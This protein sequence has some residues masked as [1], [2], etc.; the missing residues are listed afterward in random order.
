[1]H[2]YEPLPN[3]KPSFTYTNNPTNTPTGYHTARQAYIDFPEY[4]HHQIQPGFTTRKP[5]WGAVYFH[6]E[7]NLSP[8][9]PPVPEYT[10]P[11]PKN[12][13][14]RQNWKMG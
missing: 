2:T 1:M 5:L 7:T 14:I 3:T 13:E 10:T 9:K 8:L 11:T 4:I 12:L 6:N